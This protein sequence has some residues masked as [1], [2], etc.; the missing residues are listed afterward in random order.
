M[1][2]RPLVLVPATGFAVGAV[3]DDDGFA[4][5]PGLPP[6]EVRVVLAPSSASIQATPP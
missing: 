3:A 6:G 5:V 1:L 4:L 2:G